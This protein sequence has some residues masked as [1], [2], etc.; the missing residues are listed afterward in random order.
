MGTFLQCLIEKLSGAGRDS[1]PLR[2]STLYRQHCTTNVRPRE[3]VRG[4]TK[5]NGTHGDPPWHQ[6]E[7]TFKTASLTMWSGCHHSTWTFNRVLQWKAA[8]LPQSGVYDGS[9]PDKDHKVSC[10]VLR[11][12]VLQ[13]VNRSTFVLA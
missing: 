1:P 11:V 12:H 4:L 7:F 3:K 6:A 9:I 5:G 2:V 13:V 10:A 8:P